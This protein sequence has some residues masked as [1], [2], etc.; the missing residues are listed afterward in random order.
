MAVVVETWHLELTRRSH[1]RIALGYFALKTLLLYPPHAIVMRLLKRDSYVT[2]NGG[3]TGLVR[4]SL[5]AVAVVEG[6]LA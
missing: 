4:S 6:D 2:G 1:N 5:M 3:F